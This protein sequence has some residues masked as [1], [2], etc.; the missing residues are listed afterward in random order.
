MYRIS[1]VSDDVL[2]QELPDTLGSVE[3]DDPDA[4]EASVSNLWRGEGLGLKKSLIIFCF[5]QEFVQSGGK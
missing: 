2:A 1:C 5:F 3:V 4:L